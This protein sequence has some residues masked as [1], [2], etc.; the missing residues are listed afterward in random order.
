[1][2]IFALINNWHME[3]VDFVLAYPQAPIQ[4]DIYMRPPNVPQNFV[5]PDL[6]K[7][8]DRWTKV[9]K[10]IQNLY[11]LKDAGR[12]WSQYLHKGLVARGWQQSKIDSCLYTKKNIIL[13]LYV[14]DACLLSPDKS[15]IDKEIKSLQD[16]YNLT[17]DGELKDYLGTRFTRESNGSIL[18]EQPRMIQ[19]ILQMVGLDPSDDGPTHVNTHDSPASSTEI[20]DKDPEGQPHKYNWHYRSVVGCLSYLQAMTRPDLTM[21]VQQCARFCNAPK[22][23][24]GEAVK[25]ICR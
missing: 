12:T 23:S 13:V 22:A 16:Q 18:L 11:G 2:I 4:T 14:D 9:Y 19:R 25:R 20:L 7:P 3:S 24:H 6:P 21:A 8:E 15:L 10:L 1:M 17:D 5:I